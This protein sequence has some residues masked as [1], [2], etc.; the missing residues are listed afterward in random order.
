MKWIRVNRNRLC[1][2]CG[3]DSWCG[4]SEDGV[5]T[6]C[7]RIAEG[8]IE[9]RDKDGGIYYVHKNDGDRK[10]VAM[11]VAEQSQPI[12]SPDFTHSVYAAMLANF[13]PSQK[14]RQNLRQRG[15]SDS[16]IDGRKYGTMPQD[17][18]RV[19]QELSNR[20]GSS[21]AGVPGFFT[22]D[23]KI[24]LGGSCGMLVPIRDVAGRIVALL[25]RLDDFQGS[26]KYRYLSSLSHGGNGPGAPIHVPAA[27]P[28][29]CETVR[30]TEGALKADI[31]FVLTG[32]PT[33]GLP[34]LSGLPKLIETLT[35]MGC[36][37][38]RLAMDDDMRKNPM[39]ATA[40]GS[41][42]EGITKA[43]FSIEFEQW[44]RHKGIDD[45]LA[46]GVGCMVHRGIQAIRIMAAMRANGLLRSG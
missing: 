6:N 21:I 12:A 40:V 32:V 24:M 2:I 4:F 46:A 3:K 19:V 31:A 33:V 27:M 16:E 10:P 20:F 9:K 15:L 5:Y 44:Y 28:E 30:V 17:R 43:G 22:R 41:L 34:G 25:I 26:G 23:G 1:P 29:L 13:P 14:H 36:K 45:A 38:V 7:R 39:V 42:S 11:P 18:W 35:A 8:G 37:T